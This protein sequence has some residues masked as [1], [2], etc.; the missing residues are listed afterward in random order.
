MRYVFEYYTTEGRVKKINQDAVFLMQAETEK[1]NVL[2]AA[3]SDGMGGLA[4]GEEASARMNRALAAWFENELPDLVYGDLTMGN[5][6][7]SMMKAVYSACSEIMKYANGFGAECGTTLAG[8]LLLEGIAYIVN[9]GDSRIYIKHESLRQITKD[10]T[11][12][13]REIDLGRMTEEEAKTHKMRSILLQCVG[14]SDVV[15]P[16]WYQE[17]VEEGD[18]ILLCSDG[19]RHIVGAEAMDTYLSNLSTEEEMQKVL[20]TIAEKSMKAG[21]RDNITA[22]LIKVVG[23]A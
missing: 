9:V 17:Q 19:F 4:R 6:K 12:V 11:Y 8:I 16:D 22:I 13:Q 20:E 3:V 15:I 1:G 18:M 21:E 2:F 10:Q 23:D 14:A 5:F 7:K